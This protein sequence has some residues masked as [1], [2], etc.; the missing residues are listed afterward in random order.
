MT[1]LC[2][3]DS[4]S[5][6]VQDLF[7]LLGF[8]VE[9]IEDGDINSADLL[10]RNAEELEMLADGFLRA[11]A[12]YNQD[13]VP[14]HAENAG[15]WVSNVDAAFFSDTLFPD[16]AFRL[17]PLFS[18][19]AKDHGVSQSV[20]Q[21]LFA[22]ILAY[23][24]DNDTPPFYATAS[25]FVGSHENDIPELDY[26]AD[27]FVQQYLPL[28]LLTQTIIAEPGVSQFWQEIG[29][30]VVWI[31]GRDGTASGVVMSADGDIRTAYH[32]LF[33]EETGQFND[34]LYI[35]TEH[36]QYWITEGMITK[37]S[38]AQDVAWIRVPE[39][40]DFE[41]VQPIQLGNLRDMQDGD[42][43]M[44]V[45]FPGLGTINMAYA[46]REY[47]PGELVL[48]DEEWGYDFVPSP[49]EIQALILP[50]CS[51]GAVFSMNGEFLG[52]VTASYYDKIQ[53]VAVSLPMLVDR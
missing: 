23:Y 9:Q 37:K 2:T 10:A 45:G 34:D 24:S 8:S 35:T 43:V 20:A 47:S 42:P 52:T 5:P 41:E 15:T 25:V 40:A 26:L 27:L 32:V 44:V 7:S 30:S 6:D 3:F 18:E 16:V 28:S 22:N 50:G 38:S 17:Q 4:T 39:F 31:Q 13:D 1:V 14:T 49:F 46:E 51:G 19:D 12:V 21:S 36:G 11:L 33:D 53:G 29:Q 48:R